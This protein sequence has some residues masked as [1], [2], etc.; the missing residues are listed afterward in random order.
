MNTYK[1]IIGLG[2]FGAIGTYY[3]LRYQQYKIIQYEVKDNNENHICGNTFDYEY[4]P[5]IRFNPWLFPVYQDFRN[6]KIPFIRYYE[7][8]IYDDKLIY[9]SN[10]TMTMECIFNKIYTKFN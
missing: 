5:L 4:T 6:C 8:K 10:R 3:F 1:K 9:G 2:T 7:N